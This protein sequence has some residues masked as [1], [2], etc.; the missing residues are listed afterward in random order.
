[1]FLRLIEYNTRILLW[2]NTKDGKTGRNQPELVKMPSERREKSDEERQA[3]RA[4][5]DKILKIKKK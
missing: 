1:M 3:D 2:Q 4:L 5:V